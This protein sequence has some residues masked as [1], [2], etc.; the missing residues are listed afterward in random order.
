MRIGFDGKRATHNFRGLGNYSRSLID[1]IIEFAPNEEI[2][3]YTPKFRDQRAIDWIQTHQNQIHLRTPEN[4]FA[5]QFS[6]LWRSFYLEQRTHIDNLDIFH[7]LS[8]ELPFFLKKS[9]SKWIV[10]MHDLIFLRYPE[11]FPFIDRQV[12]FQKFKRASASADFILAICEQTKTDLIEILGVDE[13]KIIVHYQ[14]CDPQF[15]Q[16]ASTNQLEK[17]QQ[18]YNLPEKFILNVGA[19]EE[20]KNQLNILEAFKE[21][22]NEFSHDLVFIGQGKKYLAKVK[23]RA[24]E[25]GISKRVHFLSN[26]NYSD[27]PVFYQLAEVFCFP[28]IFEGFGIPIIESLFS[29]TPVLT[30]HGSCFPES[31]GPDSYYIDPL[32][33]HDI[34]NGLKNILSS[35]DLQLKMTTA[36]FIYADQFRREYTTEKLL[37]IYQKTLS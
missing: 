36:G 13:K 9:Q 34:A 10:T 4:Y 30:S 28:S 12:Y 37:K 24:I 25:L 22:S 15:Y 11:F 5:N 17:V 7:G 8:H 23:N 6:S 33:V 21:L 26:V 18:I 3:L 35:R 19:F 31:A 1:G 14:S 32:S 16:K 20:R 2:F 27:L 29:H